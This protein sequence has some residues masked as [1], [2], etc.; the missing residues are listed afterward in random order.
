MHIQVD[1]HQHCY[2]LLP[3]VLAA[4][5]FASS[6]SLS[7]SSGS[8]ACSPP[9]RYRKKKSPEPRSVSLSTLSTSAL[10]PLSSTDGARR[11]EGEL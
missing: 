4:S 5:S 7:P 2:Q 9:S 3:G 11:L 10:S 1:F 6:L 8:A